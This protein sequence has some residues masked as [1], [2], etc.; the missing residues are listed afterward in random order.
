VRF[1]VVVVVGLGIALLSCA[2]SSVTPAA[3]IAAATSAVTTAP[4]ASPTVAATVASTVAPTAAVP[5]ESAA[6]FLTRQIE[7]SFKAQWG[8]RWDVLLPVHQAI[9]T[10]E[11]YITCSLQTQPLTGTPQ[12][13]VTGSREEEFG[14]PALGLAT[15]P[16]TL[17]SITLVQPG[18]PPVTQTFSQHAWNVGGQWRWALGATEYNAFKNSTTA[19]S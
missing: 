9:V 17:V 7:L 2:P 3:T 15:A 12:I 4:V 19:C 1:S 18:P 14:S 11:R 5:S 10:R 6:V 8:A 13:T 16:T